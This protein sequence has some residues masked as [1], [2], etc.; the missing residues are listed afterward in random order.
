M[1]IFT[2]SGR[3]SSNTASI[4]APTTSGE[5][6]CTAR[7]PQVFCAAMAVMTVSAY[8][9][10][11]AMVLISAWMPAP[12]LE[13]EPAM[14]STAFIGNLPL[15]PALPV[16][17]LSRSMTR[18]SMMVLTVRTA[19]ILPH[20]VQVPSLLG[21]ALSKTLRGRTGSMARPNMLFPVHTATG[22]AHTV[23]AIAGAGNALGDIGGMRGDLRGDQAI[24]HILQHRAG[25][26]ARPGVHVAQEVGA[27]GGRHGAADGGG[28][29]VVARGDIGY[30][31]AEHVE[32]R[33]VAQ[34]LLQA[35]VRRDLI[36]GHM[37]RTLHHD[38]HAGVPSALGELADL[39]ELGDLASV[40]C[41]VGATR[42]HGI[43]DGD[44]HIVFMQDLENL[45]V[46]LVERVLV[47]GGLH[48]GED[49]RASAADD[50]HKSAGFLERLDGAAVHAGVDG[51]EVDAVLG[52]AADH[53]EEV[54]RLD[55]DEGLLQVAD[56]VVHGHGADHGRRLLDELGAERL[57]FAAVGKVH[58][59]LGAKLDG[60][61]DLL[62]LDGFVGKVAGDAQ[63][64]VYLGAQAL[65]D[66][67]GRQRRVVD[68]GRDGDAAGGD[69]L[70]DELRAAAFLLGD[71]AHGGRD[72]PRAGE[73]DLRDE[74]RRIRYP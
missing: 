53:I 2:A 31:R 42:T 49:E 18:P 17:S 30:E 27:R 13:S 24:A 14:L 61:I 39:D 54:L 48:P 21:G 23:V 41:V 26:G 25:A 46:M 60:R 15:T 10:Y 29:V 38:L 6:S 28:D 51:D 55:G 50:V 43:A 16:Y 19:H 3:I 32:G 70:A 69:A 5:I 52:M 58:D 67:F 33:I 56:G 36:E 65:A 9:P 20:M 62:P 45:I 4:C 34:A 11:D 73:V 44:G 57:G 74:V 47:A 37:T 59:G 12:P 63:V 66:A 7:T 35:H 72:L 22:V 8:R 71:H 1:P 40:G 64:D 68:V